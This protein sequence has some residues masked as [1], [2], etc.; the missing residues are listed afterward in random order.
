MRRVLVIDDSPTARAVLSQRLR[1]RGA[2]VQTRAS[3]HELTGFDAGEVDAVLCDVDLGDGWGPDAVT[4]LSGRVP[5]AFLSGGAEE[6][7]LD[8]ARALGPLFDKSSEVERAIAW[9]LGAA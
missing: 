4:A 2:V 6:T 5:V 9:A 7:V 8:R 3:A 1:A